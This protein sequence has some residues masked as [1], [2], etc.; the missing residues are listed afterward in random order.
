MICT[1]HNLLKLAEA[2]CRA[3][4]AAASCVDGSRVARE[5]TKDCGSVRRCLVFGLFAQSLTAGSDG[6][7]G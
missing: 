7:R 3:R 1:A 5:S 2:G 4:Q 6:P